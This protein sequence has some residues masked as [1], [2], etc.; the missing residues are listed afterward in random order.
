MKVNNIFLKNIGKHSNLKIE[1]NPSINLIKGANGSGK[2]TIINAIKVLSD[3][4]TKPQSVL[5]KIITFNKNE[6]L[7]KIDYS[8]SNSI[9]SL[10]LVS[11]NDDYKITFNNKNV[12]NNYKELINS[13]IFTP[14]KFNSFINKPQS[15]RYFFDNYLSILI[16]IH[17]VLLTEFDSL[18]RQRNESLRSN[19]HLIIKLITKKMVKIQDQIITNRLKF[20]K[21][22]N[23]LLIKFDFKKFKD[24]KTIEIS[25]KLP[26][27]NTEDFYKNN[28]KKDLKNGYTMNSINTTD[29]IVSINKMNL[30]EYGSQGQKR[31]VYIL[32]MILLSDK[33]WS[34]S[35]EPVLIFDD[36]FSELDLNNTF[37]IVDLI[38]KH[39]Q[40]IITTS[41]NTFDN[42]NYK[43]INL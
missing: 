34:I 15:R 11:Y 39:L 16:P 18:I 24:F 27:E 31:L 8:K 43:T 10:K 14:E 17:K 2:T 19:N 1:F 29:F 42:K 22:I 25:H 28:L 9:N 12:E 3:N 41:K 7:I 40:V 37:N 33:N 32:L 21:R 23:E 13:F 36:A 30:I 4:T 5:K 26:F 35:R 20:L 38:P 6:S